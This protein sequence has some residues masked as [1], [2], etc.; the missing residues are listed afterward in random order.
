[1]FDNARDAHLYL[2]NSYVKYNN[3]PVFVLRVDENKIATFI[4]LKRGGIEENVHIDELDLSPFKLGYYH[5]NVYKRTYY[6]ERMPV[7]AWRSGLTRENM[8]VKGDDGIR[9]PANGSISMLK[10]LEP[11]YRPLGE[12]FEIAKAERIEYPFHRRFS[13]DHEGMIKYKTRLIGGYGEGEGIVL[14]PSFKWMKEL[15]EVSL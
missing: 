10:I 12:S 6:I 8:K 7:R 15:V 4:N 11:N 3:K 1:M 5:D 13:V 2:H 9:L 14:L